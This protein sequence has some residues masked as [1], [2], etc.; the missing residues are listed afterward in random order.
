MMKKQET[1]FAV[2]VE[3]G[4][5]KEV[6]K[7]YVYVPASKFTGGTIQWHEDKRKVRKAV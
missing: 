1:R 3:N 2:K 5:V 6:G 7:S 4:V